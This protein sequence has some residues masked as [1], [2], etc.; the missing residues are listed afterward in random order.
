VG[1]GAPRRP[2]LARLLD[3]I[4]WERASLDS[5]SVRAK[6]G[7]E[8]TG[9]NPTDRGKRGTKYHLLVDDQG[10]PLAAL[11]LAAN[12]HDSLLLE[13]VV[14]AVP[15]IWP[16]SA[17]RAALA[18]GSGLLRWHKHA[19]RDWGAQVREPEVSLSS[20][21]MTSTRRSSDG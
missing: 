4:R 8:A 18:A 1:G 12:V 6:R 7:G 10:V 16:P 14:D 15:P 20:A 11:V 13:L 21:P 3:A 2:E 9:P 19:E 17:R 5:A